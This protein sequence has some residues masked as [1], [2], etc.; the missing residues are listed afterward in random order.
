MVFVLFGSFAWGQGTETFTNLNASGNS[1]T[2]GSFVGDNSV[3]WSYNGTRLISSTYNINGT[4]A[5][6]GTSGLRNMN[7]QSGINGVG[8]I[9]YSTRSYFTG[10]G[11]SDRSL[12]VYVNGVLVDSYTLASMDV[13]YTRTTTVNV[14]GDVTIEIRATG[15]RQ[16][17][18]DDISWTAYNTTASIISANTTTVSGLDYTTNSGPSTAQTFSVT[19][20][21]LT[22]DITVSAPTNFEVSDALGGTY[23]STIT[24]PSTGGDVYTRL[25]AG[26]TA[27]TYIGD[28]TLS[29][30]GASDVTVSVEGT[31][32]DPVVTPP[33]A[34]PATNILTNGFTANWDAVSGADSYVLEVYEGVG[35]SDLIISEYVEGSNSNK[36]IEIFNGTGAPVDL[37][38]YSLELYS[39]GSTSDGSPQ[40]L[41]GTLNNGEVVVYAHSSA[42]I[43]S[44]TT[45]SFHQNIF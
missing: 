18:I 14:S 42:N 36:Y 13:V 1:Y 34:N 2:S 43:Y 38:G 28:I 40:V 30:T 8:D 20:S 7:A 16:I 21:N 19:G 29:S 9:T 5:G 23:T 26:L 37:S 35:L 39:N 6:F 11:A 22:T 27:N 33:V 12:E 15:S 31:V 44:G 24:L 32:S 45:T 25:V 41:S 17:A 4:S 10:G 3:T